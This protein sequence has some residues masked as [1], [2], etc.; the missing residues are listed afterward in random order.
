MDIK[1][2]NDFDYLVGKIM[3]ICSKLPAGKYSFYV[4]PDRKNMASKFFIKHYFNEKDYDDKFL[5]SHNDIEIYYGKYIGESETIR[6]DIKYI[7]GDENLR[8]YKNT[9]YILIWETDDWASGIC[10]PVA[11]LMLRFNNRG[12]ITSVKRINSEL[13]DD[14]PLLDYMNSRAVI[15]DETAQE[16]ISCVWDMMYRMYDRYVSIVKD[17]GRTYYARY[18]CK[19]EERE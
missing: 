10:Y 14:R 16:T 11:C 5:R 15:T 6:R 19:K 4:T 3:S 12:M 9:M 13:S 17:N 7:T 2:T 18:R 8:I 1:M